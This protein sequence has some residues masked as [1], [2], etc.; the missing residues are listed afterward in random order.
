MRTPGGKPRIAV[1]GGAIRDGLRGASRRPEC[2]IN[3]TFDQRHAMRGNPAD[4]RQYQ[5]ADHQHR[6][7]GRGNDRRTRPPRGSGRW[8]AR[9]C[10]VPRR[11]I[12]EL[13]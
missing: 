7:E 9:L 10:S 13:D 12:D 11:P 2:S 1:A 6:R 8:R 4:R 3:G 5:R